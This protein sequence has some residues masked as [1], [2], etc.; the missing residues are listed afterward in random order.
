MKVHVIPVDLLH[1]LF[2][3]TIC[4]ICDKIIYFKFH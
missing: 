3:L 2:I 4:K 1:G